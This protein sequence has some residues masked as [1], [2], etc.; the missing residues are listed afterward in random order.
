MMAYKSGLILLVTMLTIVPWGIALF[1]QKVE[2]RS[3]SK[4]FHLKTKSLFVLLLGLSPGKEFV[5]VGPAIIQVWT[6][7]YLVSCLIAANLW[8][9]DGVLKTTL[10]VYFG[11]LVILAILGWINIILKQK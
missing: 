3:K 10:Y 7:I 9:S 2:N 4:A 8:G 11:G 1:I 6:L 5:Y